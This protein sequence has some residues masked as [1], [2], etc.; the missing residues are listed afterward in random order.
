MGFEKNPQQQ[1]EVRRVIRAHNPHIVFVGLGFPKQDL[2]VRELRREFPAVWFVGCGAAIVMLAGEVSRAP[3]WMQR[4]G[5]EW[6]YRLVMEP[7]RL[8]RRYII[9]DIPFVLKLI[10]RRRLKSPT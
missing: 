5:L 6:A 8:F 10:S 4:F 1:A 3:C 2:L 7:R 9:E